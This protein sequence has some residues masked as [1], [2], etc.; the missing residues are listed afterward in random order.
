MQL[1]CCTFEAS[2]NLILKQ[3]RKYQRHIAPSAVLLFLGL[4]LM[5]G[6]KYSLDKSNIRNLVLETIREGVAPEALI[7]FK[8]TQAESDALNWEKRHEFELN[9]EMYD[10]VETAV[11]NDTIIYQCFHDTKETKFKRKFFKYLTYYLLPSNQSE[12]DKQQ[13]TKQIKNY[14]VESVSVVKIHTFSVVKV[15]LNWRYANFYD[16]LLLGPNAPPPKV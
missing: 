2:S 5:V 6:L 10:V 8:F 4:V 7:E 15:S 9:G 3:I 1:Y 16:Y 12:D 11:V 13:S 14:I